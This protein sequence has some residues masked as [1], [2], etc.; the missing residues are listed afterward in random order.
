MARRQIIHSVLNEHCVPET[1]PFGSVW[2]AKAEGSFWY[3]TLDGRV[4]CL[5]DVLN[6]V[7]VHLPPRHGRDGID[8]ALGPKGETGAAGRDG[9]N[10]SAGRDGVNATGIQGPQGRPGND[11]R[12][13]IANA[14]RVGGLESALAELRS[15]IATLRAEVANVNLQY[16]A[17]LDSNQTA[18]DYLGWLR[19]KTAARFR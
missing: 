16:K 12:D 9:Q 15:T 4:V 11:G 10:G 3:A 6:N 1:A 2:I 19:A 17:I 13:S 14:E 8:G 5:S 18:S 7:P